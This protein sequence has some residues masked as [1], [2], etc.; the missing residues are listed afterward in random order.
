M[1]GCESERA[2]IT[3]TVSLPNEIAGSLTN[4]PLYYPV[5]T[6]IDDQVTV[7]GAGTITNPKVYIATGFQAGDALVYAGTLPS[8][9]TQVY[10]SATGSLNFTG[11][12]TSA[13]WQ[14]IFR[15]VTFTSTHKHR[16][17]F[18]NFLIV[19]GEFHDQ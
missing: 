19:S 9:I 7:T 10:N 1:G 8:G 18:I 11:S 16:R 17:S 2:K 4:K 14:T 3:I 15:G 13:T 12:G 6:L 5:A